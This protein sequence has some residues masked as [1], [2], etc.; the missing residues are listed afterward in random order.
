MIKTKQGL[1]TVIEILFVVL[2]F[3]FILTI[4]LPPKQTLVE[5]FGVSVDSYF[6]T[7][8]H[9]STNR[10]IFI[11]ENLSNSSITGNWTNITN[12]LSRVFN[13]YYL[14][15]GNLTFSKQISSC[16]PNA[17]EYRTQRIVAIY[18]NSNYKFRII[19]LGVCY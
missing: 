18:N 8:T 12:Q 4:L 5:N 19:T 7:I 14:S 16:T 1:F 2:L 15:I 3:G 11:Q 17:G 9:S 13:S 6:S 10:I